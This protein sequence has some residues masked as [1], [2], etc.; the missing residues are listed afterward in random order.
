VGNPL[1]MRGGKGKCG[2]V[3][4][5]T[6]VPG[7][8]ENGKWTGSGREIGTESRLSFPSLDPKSRFTVFPSCPL[9]VQNPGAKHVPSPFAIKTLSKFI[10]HN[11]VCVISTETKESRH[12]YDHVDEYV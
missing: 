2:I 10:A 11:I 8:R 7:L 6:G 9:P 4:F 1:N 12:T 3:R 5:F